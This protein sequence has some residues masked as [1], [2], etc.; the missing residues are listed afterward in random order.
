MYGELY[1]FHTNMWWPKHNTEIILI[2]DIPLCL[3]TKSK[4][5]CLKFP[6]KHNS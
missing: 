2:E 5:K 4:I 1:M 6:S 3:N